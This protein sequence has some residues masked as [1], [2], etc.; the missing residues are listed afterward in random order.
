M[1]A[2]N[3]SS[4]I[5]NGIKKL[6]KVWEIGIVLFIL[7]FAS[8]CDIIGYDHN[9]PNFEFEE[10][11]A[12][13]PQS[14][15]SLS[16]QTGKAP[17]SVD[18]TD[19]SID[20]TASITIWEWDF[21]DGGSSNE[22]NPQYIY[23]TAGSY[24]VSLT[25][26]STDGSDTSTQVEAVIVDPEDTVTKITIVD[27]RGIPLPDVS[28]TSEVFTVEAT[29][30]NEMSQLLLSTRPSGTQGVVRLQKEG[31]VDGLLFLDGTLLNSTQSVT[32]LTQ[33]PPII[34]DATMGGEY[35]GMDGASVNL[36]DNALVKADGSMVIG[37]VELYI[38]PVDISDPIKKQAFPGSFIGLPDEA[39]IPDGDPL[40]YLI[41]SYGVVEYSFYQDGEEL[42]LADGKTAD[43][44]L[45]LY[46]D[47]S[48]Y[49]EDIQVGELIPLWTLNESTGIWIQEGVGEVI[50]NPIAESGLSLSAQTTHFSS[51]NADAWA[52]FGGGGSGGGAGGA[53]GGRGWCD[54]ALD[55][56]GSDPARSITYTFELLVNP[57]WNFTRTIQDNFI[58]GSV[59]EGTRVRVT[60]WQG[61]DKHGM[62]IFGCS[63]A[64][65]G[66][67][68]LSF[69]DSPPE[70]REWE[71]KAEPIFEETSPGEGYF[72]NRNNIR[73]GGRFVGTDTVDIQTDLLEA[74]IIGLA[75]MQYT[76]LQFDGTL[77]ASPTTIIATLTNDEGSVSNTDT[78]DFIASQSPDIDFF[79]A[80]V[81]QNTINY[82]WSVKGADDAAVYYLDEDPSAL[83]LLMFQIEDV[84][85]GFIQNS[86]LLNSTGFIRI[87]F[88]NTYGSS[89]II[90]RMAQL[91]CIEGSELPGC[92]PTK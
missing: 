56:I 71:I 88:S 3:L 10:Q 60:A 27:A 44:Q 66:P 35:I 67:I 65:L 29:A 80:N 58:D 53:G 11:I 13:T 17:L 48:L 78:I 20:G 81:G 54:F 28:V 77:H 62:A 31:Y 36:P 75:S 73:V 85:S 83:G 40:E 14:D 52:G 82:Q 76:D 37:D 26:T 89:V 33:H 64:R 38:T 15:F 72:I 46:V 19:E 2:L 59:P 45:P 8:G 84:E 22:Q 24:D 42:Q 5:P 69:G 32:L 87:E 57:S 92:F 34:F 51:F 7:I 79:F 21:G 55:F 63:D 50:A 1:L 4:S 6:V 49:G 43:L 41:V 70:F 9:S 30:S 68:G 47:Q 39:D 16:A 18:F 74:D 86:Q 12:E 25:V 61:D 23:E 90:A 91:T